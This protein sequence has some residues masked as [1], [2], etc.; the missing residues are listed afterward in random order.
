MNK[1]TKR[2][3]KRHLE[4]DFD[5]A[6]ISTLLASFSEVIDQ[7]E[8]DRLMLERSLMLTSDELNE[9]ND[10][11]KLQLEEINSVKNELEKS[12]IKQQA[13][14]NAS[15]E[16]VI[17]FT[18][19]G[20][21]DQINKTA[22]LFLGQTLEQSKDQSPR[23][24]LKA[25]LG[26]I[27]SRSNI[28]KEIRLSKSSKSQKIKGKFQTVSGHH[29]EYSIIPELLENVILGSIFSFRDISDTQNNQDLL[30]YKAYH[31][32]LTGLPN[33]NSILNTIQHALILAKRHKEQ[34][35]ILF[36]DLDDFKKIN[37]TAGHDE[38]DRFLIEVSQRL[39]SVLRESDTLG[40]LGGDEFIIL[41]ENI[42]SSKQ[43]TDIHNRALAALSKSF[44][45]DQNPYVVS[46]SIGISAY[47]SDGSESEELIRKADMA[48]YQAKKLGK[49]RFHYFDDNL[50]RLVIHR[51]K[52]EESLRSAIKNSEFVL[53]YQPK[54]ELENNK[55]ELIGFEALIRWKREDGSITY[56]DSFITLAEENG[57]IRSLT[58]WVIAEAC[59]QIRIWDD[60]PLSGIPI[61]V[62]ISA[63]DIADNNFV[64][65]TLSILEENK[66]PGHL[67]ELELTESVFFDDVNSVNSKLEKLRNHHLKLSLDDFGTGYSSFSY[68]QD[69]QIDYIKI[70]KSFI[71]GM[72]KNKRSLAIVQ[73]IIDMG[74]NLG[75]SVIAEGVET[76]EDK[77]TLIKAGCRIAQGYLY[78]RPSPA[79]EISERFKHHRYIS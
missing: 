74:E 58:K 75:L 5:L 36:I 59:R 79:S 44:L 15:Q 57:L 41:L 40:R 6:Q 14:L 37:D 72:S 19:E 12:F 64:E 1:L 2:L 46:C 76:V 32:D 39:K 43:I 67:I 35:A 28:I 22:L 48:M 18:S 70:D 8:Q 51:V 71:L 31:D 68:L 29:Y 78:G 26:K 24:I 16:G 53:Y 3:V 55:E 66:V 13:L 62:N 60:T 34:C 7:Y 63:I 52:T 30:K 4:T 27:Q 17:S 21:I 49:N 20:S 47:P 11:L 69:L 54:V 25:L 33:R 10:T 56:P 50:E 65:S 45:I 42:S 77:E 38:G 23:G 9:I 61:S 73:S